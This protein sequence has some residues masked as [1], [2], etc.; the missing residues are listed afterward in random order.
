MKSLVRPFV[1]A[2]IASLEHAH[3][4]VQ[5]GDPVDLAQVVISLDHMA[6]LLLKAA[7]LERGESIFEPRGRKTL[8]LPATLAK[9]GSPHAAEI[10]VVHEQRNQVQH[11]FAYGQP[12]EAAEL[13]DTGWRFAQELL[14][15]ELA[16][17][18]E[19]ET[20]VR[21]PSVS[22][23]THEGAPVDP[24]PHLQ[25]DAAACNNVLAWADGAREISVSGFE[26][27]TRNPS[28]LR[29]PMASNT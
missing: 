19:Q 28:G 8:G 7:M 21:P 4:H 5:G 14:A 13:F 22:P 1:R 2:A 16:L 24:A 12:A 10:E 25:R 11:F 6:E 26:S 15:R 18:L 23:V 27:M 3:S 9:V 20:Q 29:P 17:T